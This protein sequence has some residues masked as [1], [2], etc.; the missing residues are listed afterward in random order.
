M[1]SDLSKGVS[2]S[3]ADIE[4]RDSVL[5]WSEQRSLLVDGDWGERSC[6]RNQLTYNGTCGET[7][8]VVRIRQWWR[9]PC[10]DLDADHKMFCPNSTV[11]FMAGGKYSC[12]VHVWTILSASHLSFLRVVPEILPHRSPD[13]E[14]VT[15]IAICWLLW[16]ESRSPGH[17]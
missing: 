8:P 2:S 1:C 16:R 6:R 10:H 9:Q 14:P 15:H 5:L 11:E 12:Q 7:V 3:V 17:Q 4:V 13:W